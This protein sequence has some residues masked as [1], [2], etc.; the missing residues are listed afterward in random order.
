MFFIKSICKLYRKK[1]WLVDIDCRDSYV[2]MKVLA[3]REDI[4][5]YKELSILNR[6]HDNFK[7][8]D[9]GFQHLVLTTIVPIDRYFGLMCVFQASR[10]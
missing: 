8:C 9:Y 1:N 2:Q 4:N 5:P 6:L 3:N 10:F 7:M